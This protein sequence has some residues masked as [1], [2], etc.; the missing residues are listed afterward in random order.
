MTH[1]SSSTLEWLKVT[2]A[3]C[4]TARAAP[5]ARRPAGS[6]NASQALVN[7]RRVTDIRIVLPTARAV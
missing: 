5:P 6:T 1:A 4:R 3:V 2:L 7:H